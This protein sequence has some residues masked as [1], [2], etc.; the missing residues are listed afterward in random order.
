[1]TVGVYIGIKW[2]AIKGDYRS[3][4]NKGQKTQTVDVDK[5]SAYN[6]LLELSAAQTNVDKTTTELLDRIQYTYHL[7]KTMERVP[8]VIQ[9]E[10]GGNLGGI[11]RYVFTPRYLNPDKEVNQASKKATKYTGIGYLGIESGVSFSLGYFADCYIDFGYFGMMIPLLLLGLIYGYTYFYFITKTSHN[12]LINIAFVSAIF[13][14][15]IYF[16]SDGTFL[17]GRL[18]S[19]ILTFYLFKIF[20][21]PTIYGYINSNRNA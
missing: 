16:E 19:N 10:N 11:F 3:Y 12:Y 8:G 7:A 2:T 5:N 17:L 18:A 6:K 20:L 1:L 9:Y 13:M 14:E 15:L 21:M 4:L